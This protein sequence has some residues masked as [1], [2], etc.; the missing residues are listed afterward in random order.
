MFKIE[1]KEKDFLYKSEFKKLR[2]ICNFANKLLEK[3]K[4]KFIE[5][6]CYLSIELSQFD[7]VKEFDVL[8]QCG[9]DQLNVFDMPHNHNL[10]KLTEFKSFFDKFETSLKKWY[11]L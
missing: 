11:I 6:E 10:S 3:Y 2:T 8:F 1:F 5:E 7:A 4:D 9:D